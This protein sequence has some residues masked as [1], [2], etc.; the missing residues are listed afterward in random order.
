MV[1]R[2]S[3]KVHKHE[4]K[5]LY[6]FQKSNFFVLSIKRNSGRVR[7]SKSFDNEY[8]IKITLNDGASYSTLDRAEDFNILAEDIETYTYIRDN[9]WDSDLYNTNFDFISSMYD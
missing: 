9:T 3:V 8:W 5:S 2:K 4:D 1:K 7:R 6:Q